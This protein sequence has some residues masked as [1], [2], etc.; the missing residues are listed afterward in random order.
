ME[1][2]LTPIKAF[3][4]GAGGK[5]AGLLGLETS[6]ELPGLLVLTTHAPA[7][8]WSSSPLVKPSPSESLM[9]SALLHM[10]VVGGELGT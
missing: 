9:A 2:A 3:M 5:L 1:L 4:V 10:W 6:A 7:A 8:S